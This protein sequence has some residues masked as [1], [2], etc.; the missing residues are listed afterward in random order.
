VVL[1]ICPTSNVLTG[2]VDCIKDHPIRKLMD[3]GVRVTLNSDDPQF[4]GISLSHEYQI[5]SRELD[6]SAV[7]FEKLNAE[8]LKATFISQDLVQKAWN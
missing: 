5:L 4:F 8:A 1:E 7:D 2:A 3:A 6:F